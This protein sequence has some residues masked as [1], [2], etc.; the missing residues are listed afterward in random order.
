MSRDLLTDRTARERGI[1][2]SGEAT[3]LLDEHQAGVDH[4]ERLWNLTVL[5]LWFR[6]FVDEPPDCAS[7]SRVPTELVETPAAGGGLHCGSAPFL[8]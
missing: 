4:G 7:A 8:Q 1:I 6:A 3:R 5:E 2:D